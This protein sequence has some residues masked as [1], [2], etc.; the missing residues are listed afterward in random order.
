MSF[1]KEEILTL[2]IVVDVKEFSPE[3]PGWLPI[4]FGDME[5]SELVGRKFISD[6]V[7]TLFE[8]VAN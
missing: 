7:T 3:P 2:R 4:V 6:D 5:I 8:I 1:Q